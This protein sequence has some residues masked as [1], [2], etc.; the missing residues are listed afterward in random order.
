MGKKHKI[1]EDKNGSAPKHADKV[2]ISNYCELG[3]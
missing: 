3:I 1:Y 2:K